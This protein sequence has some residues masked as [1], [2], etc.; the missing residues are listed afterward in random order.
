M[1]HG[2]PDRPQR[3][4][5]DLVCQALGKYT[6]YQLSEM[7]HQGSPGATRQRS[8]AGALNRSSE[9]LLD[10]EVFEYFSAL[11]SSDSEG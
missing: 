5:V 4:S 8:G 7:A 1:R 3:D 6:A 9:P 2:R 11:V 10:E